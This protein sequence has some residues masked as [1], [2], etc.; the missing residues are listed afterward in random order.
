MG[1]FEHPGKSL[2]EVTAELKETFSAPAVSASRQLGWNLE[3]R[4]VAACFKGNPLF[5]GYLWSVWQIFQVFPDGREEVHSGPWIYCDRLQRYSGSWWH[6]PIGSESDH[7]YVYGCPIKY[8]NMCQ[9]QDA[10]WRKQVT[11]QAAATKARRKKTI[12]IS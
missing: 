5:S 1:R 11:D 9:T 8:L 6:K 12:Y 4:C 10:S 3:R 2:R 7:P